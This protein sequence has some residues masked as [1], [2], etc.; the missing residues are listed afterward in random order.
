MV[1]LSIILNL[2]RLLS[3]YN[4]IFFKININIILNFQLTFVETTIN[5]NLYY[6]FIVTLILDVYFIGRAQYF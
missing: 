5:V 4:K 6:T 2:K 1:T 3:N